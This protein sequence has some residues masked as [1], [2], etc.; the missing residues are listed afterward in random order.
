MTVPL[1]T[2]PLESSVREAAAILMRHRLLAVPVVSRLGRMHGVIDPSTFGRDASEAFA[3]PTR[4]EL[5]AAIGVSLVSDTAERFRTR[6]F[7]LLWTV[8]GGLVAAMLLQSHADLLHRAATLVLFLPVTL[9]LSER[10]GVHGAVSA[11]GRLPLCRCLR[12]CVA[13]ALRTE[14]PVAISLA[15]ASGVLLATVSAGWFEP[16]RLPLTLSLAV[17]GA[18]TA[19]AVLGTSISVLAQRFSLLSRGWVGPL[20]LA[21]ADV[22]SVATYLGAASWLV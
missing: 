11:L 1:V 2:V 14:L 10:A 6:W 3:R 7:A 18:M 17:A 5:L 22:V 20:V 15:V 9:A 16:W 21:V 4:E 13:A 19:A 8:V 12:C